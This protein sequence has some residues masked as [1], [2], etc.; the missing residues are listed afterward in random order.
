MISTKADLK[1]YI[2][3]DNGYLRNES[4]APRKAYMKRLQSLPAYL[5]P[6]FLNDKE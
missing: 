1:N 6:P 4:F 2:E 3:H 5:S